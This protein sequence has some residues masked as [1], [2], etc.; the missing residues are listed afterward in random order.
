MPLSEFNLV[1][2]IKFYAPV[3][4]API[5]EKPKGIKKYIFN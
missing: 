3:A 2:S 4:T 1:A 5:G